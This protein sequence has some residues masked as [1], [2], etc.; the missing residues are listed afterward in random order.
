[1]GWP[2]PEEEDVVAERHVS[3]PEVVRWLIIHGKSSAVRR[4]ITEAKRNELQLCF[5]ELDGNGDGLI[6]AEELQDYL[7]E[8]RAASRGHT[9]S[10]GGRVRG[11]LQAT[12]AITFDDFVREVM[13]QPSKVRASAAPILARSCSVRRCV[14]RAGAPLH[15]PRVPKVL[16]ASQS[17]GELLNRRQSSQSEGDHPHVEQPTAPKSV[18]W[19]TFNAYTKTYSDYCQFKRQYEQRWTADEYA[20][21]TSPADR[22]TTRPLADTTVGF[23]PRSGGRSLPNLAIPTTVAKEKRYRTPTASRTDF[24]AR[25]ELC[26]PVRAQLAA[27]K[28]AWRTVRDTTRANGPTVGQVERMERLLLQ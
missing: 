27:R 13:A 25:D 11:P 23:Y 12:Q 5:E 8:L 17:E 10:G 4:Q 16:V 2:H 18:F 28:A 1:M 24:V 19:D 20:S 15:F 3:D 26:A 14:S 9:S 22:G 21:T 6:D 7:Q